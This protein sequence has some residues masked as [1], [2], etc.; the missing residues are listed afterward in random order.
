MPPSPGLCAQ[1]ACVWEVMARKPGNV[2]PGCA[3]ADMTC[4]DFLLSALAVGPVLDAAAGH[5]VGVTVL[6][7]VR[8]TRRVV[9]TNTNLGILLLLA[10][11]AAVPPGQELRAGLSRVLDGLDVEDARAAFEAIRLAR[12]GGLGS[13]AEQDVGEAPTEPLG[14]VMA[15]AA[16]RDLIARQYVDGFREVFE[17]GVPALREALGRA[18]RLEGAIISAHLRLMASHPDSLITRKRG[19]AEAEEAARRAAAVLEAGWPGTEAAT[20]ALAGL[21]TWLRADSNAR[22]PGT[23][24]DL[25]A[26][27]LFVALREEV[28]RLPLSLPW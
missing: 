20:A 7:G 4:Q 18:G 8:A 14:R 11:L 3:F 19:R 6:E 17:D 27:S 2:H 16:G 22:N 5:G 24:A 10:P 1:V 25:V 26:A 15:L 23:T 12:P 21:D 9:Q 28:I 13:V